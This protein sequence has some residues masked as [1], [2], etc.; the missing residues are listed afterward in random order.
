MVFFTY[1]ISF[2]LTIRFL[3]KKVLRMSSARAR[4]LKVLA[5]INATEGEG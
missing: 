3:Q 1:F 2:F 4:S 5:L